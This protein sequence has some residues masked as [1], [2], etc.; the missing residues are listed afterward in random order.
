M[1]FLRDS[2]LVLALCAGASTPLAGAAAVRP[3]RAA[4]ASPAPQVESAF[5]AAWAL[6]ESG[7]PS[8]EAFQRVLDDATQPAK[9]RFNA[10][11]VLAVQSL[12][13]RDP[14][15]ALALLGRA[16]GLL[17]DRP[18]VRLRR[19][20]A[21]LQLDR[22]EEAR[23]TLAAVALGEQSPPQ[24]RLRHALTT[25]MLLHAEGRSDLAIEALQ[26][27]GEAHPKQWEPFYLMGLVYESFDLP[28]DAMRAYKRAIE[29]DPG[30][31]PFPGIYAYQRW[32][33]MAISL[34]PRNHRCARA[35]ATSSSRRP[36]GARRQCFVDDMLRPPSGPGAR[37]AGSGSGC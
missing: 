17:P 23:A 18:Q 24:L 1:S 5:E 10:A 30:R 12:A 15:G 19:T 2:L 22:L 9:E 3:T 27:L 21:L 16:E 34:D 25:A 31:D 7:E 36:R 26:R 32:A 28:E 8:F 35:T 11:Y 37:G 13:R 33:A 29:N 20:D 14:E 4:L 6:Y